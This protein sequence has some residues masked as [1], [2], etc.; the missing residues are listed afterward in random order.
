MRQRYL[1]VLLLGLGNRCQAGL[2]VFEDP[3]PYTYTWAGYSQ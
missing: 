3:P 1:P 2:L